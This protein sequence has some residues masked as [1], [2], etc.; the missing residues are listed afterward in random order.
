MKALLSI[1][2]AAVCL[3]PVAALA[4][5]PTA[6]PA[7]SSTATSLASLTE[8]I[9]K[10]LGEGTRGAKVSAEA[11]RTD[12]PMK[13]GD[14]LVS[15]LTALV[16]GRIEQGTSKR[17]L[18]STR[19]I[20]LKVELAKGDLRVTA[21]LL[22]VPHNRWDR[23]KSR[24]AV[25]VAHAFAS[26]PVDAEIRAY[27]APIVLEQASIHRAKHDE[28]DTLA[29]AC[30]DIDGDGGSELA[31]V[32]RARISIGR[33]RGG[34]FVAERTRLWTDV[35]KRLPVPM[36]EPI[37]AAS[38]GAGSLFAGTTDYGGYRFGVALAGAATATPGLPL[39]AL[40]GVPL[41]AASSPDGSGFDGLL[42]SC[43]GNAT[44]LL[45]STRFDA[46]AV[47]RFR[48]KA[49]KDEEIVAAREST[50][51][52]RLRSSLRD[53]S[54]ALENAGAQVLLADLDL[55]G[56]PELV[57]SSDGQQDDSAFVYSWRPEGLALRRKIPAPQGVRGFA[58][59]PAEEGAVPALAMLVGS[60]VWLVR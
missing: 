9:T 39:V 21:D 44:V 51:R 5:A 20:V 25:I 60:E 6:A 32:S 35:G 50:G 19:V 13:R 29:I 3:L 57:T 1:M 40:Q 24:D 23:L 48:S 46:A 53:G 11:L 22:Q 12:Q 59:C 28:V 45:P 54:L 58:A 37:G 2:F 38:L 27:M 33:L 8:E 31:I 17:P 49:G 30:G 15:A 34:R 36:M 55:D 4:D 18:S 14:E 52:L 16:S 10:Q 47:L 42:R 43:E 41:C 26:R 7:Q 56:V